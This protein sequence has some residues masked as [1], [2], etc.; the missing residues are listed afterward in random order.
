[1]R[2]FYE[3]YNIDWAI[4][5][6]GITQICI[7][8]PE[9]L[10]DF[11]NNLWQQN[12]GLQGE[13]FLSSEDK[14]ISLS[15][16]VAVVFNPFD[17]DINDKK[18][19]ARLYQNLKQYSDVDFLSET[20]AINSSIVSLLENITSKE[21]YPIN[22]DLELDMLQLFKLY[23]VRFDVECESLIENVC[24]YIKLMHQVLG[25]Q[26]FVFEFLK[27]YLTDEERKRFSEMV[28]YEQVIVILIEHSSGKF[29]NEKCWIIDYDKCIIEI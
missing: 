24:N 26:V 9:V 11:S 29:N 23:A 5:N 22:F 2:F 25:T 14:M 8:N 21:P 28:A 20:L 15:K 19:I 10:S 7:E 12:Q 16:D 27:N 13:I 6:F 17:I 4:E 18:I 1:M 3:K